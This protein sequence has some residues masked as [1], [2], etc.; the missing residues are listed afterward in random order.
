L[1]AVVAAR[2]AAAAARLLRGRVIGH[3]ERGPRGVEFV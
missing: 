2:E 3:I 1:V